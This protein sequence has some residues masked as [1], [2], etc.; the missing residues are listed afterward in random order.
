MMKFVSEVWQCQA[1]KDICKPEQPACNLSATELSASELAS[2]LRVLDNQSKIHASNLPMMPWLSAFNVVWCEEL[3]DIVNCC[4]GFL[5]CFSYI[6]C[7]CTSQ[8]IDYEDRFL[9]QSTDWLG[10]FCPIVWK[11]KGRKKDRDF[12]STGSS[13]Y[14]SWV[15]PWK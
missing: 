7:C 9:H 4:L 12:S 13:L 14:W 3:C 1:M 8:V 6:L 10:T 15:R 11:G 5:C 2:A